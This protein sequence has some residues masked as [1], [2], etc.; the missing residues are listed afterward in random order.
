MTRT[1]FLG[2]NYVPEPVVVLIIIS[3]LRQGYLPRHS[4]LSLGSITLNLLALL[5]I[6]LG[7]ILTSGDLAAV[8][9]DYRCFFLAFLFYKIASS[10]RTD[11]LDAM[12]SDMTW[13][14][15]GLF[16]GYLF[17]YLMLPELQYDSSAAAGGS[18][19]SVKGI[20]PVFGLLFLQFVAI[21][22]EST[23]LVLFTLALS[24]YIALTAF[25]R[26]G[27]FLFI[28]ILIWSVVYIAGNAT[29]SHK[30][31][32]Y[33]AAFLVISGTLIFL[34]A[35]SFSD[36]I[37]SYLTE[38]AGRQSQSVAK[39]ENMALMFSG[40]AGLGEGDDIRVGYFAFI[41]DHLAG[42]M[43][44]SGFGHRA[45][46]DN[47][48]TLWMPDSYTVI[49]SN[50]I[51]G[52]HLYIAAH[53]GI[54]VGLTAFVHLIRKTVFLSRRTPSWS[55]ACHVIVGAEFFLCGISS[56]NMFSIVPSAIA[57]G[58]ALGTIVGGNRRWLPRRNSARDLL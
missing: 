34:N 55:V 50:S 14:I 13:L 17:S 4:F 36:F 41:A 56:G 25:Y 22:K 23:S 38:N 26:S 5:M 20:Y 32:K 49:G 37:Y 44:P 33:I 9:A 2:G 18:A 53:F 54:L 8:Y 7:A 52:L 16:V 29:D 57:F 47:W 10:C 39:L 46:I 3:L 48:H 43:L 6:P 19:A 28:L 11:R 40:Q 27:I 42:F 21:R 35:I 58:L 15:L 1:A 30:R 12:T 24:A 45:L 51:D 31:V